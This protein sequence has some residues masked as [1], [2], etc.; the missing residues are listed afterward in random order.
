LLVLFAKEEAWHLGQWKL[1]RD[2]K[3]V[4]DPLLRSEVIQVTMRVIVFQLRHDSTYHAHSPD[5]GCFI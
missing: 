4:G 2:S 1:T 5:E 3:I